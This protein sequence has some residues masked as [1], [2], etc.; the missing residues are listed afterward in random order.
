MTAPRITRDTPPEWIAQQ[1]VAGAMTML[2]VA[3][4][5]GT[6]PWSEKIWRAVRDLRSGSRPMAELIAQ[7][8]AAQ[9]AY[10][11]MLQREHSQAEFE[12][13]FEEFDL[14]REVVLDTAATT[15]PEVL[16]KIAAAA[17]EMRSTNDCEWLHE[18]LVRI[19]PDLAVVPPADAPAV[20]A[21]L[22]HMLPRAGDEPLE[23][24]EEAPLR[25]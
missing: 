24:E 14:C 20:L 6:G 10:E 9:A 18:H 4:E 13:L 16:A 5:I 23:G 8:D 1:V 3:A 2:D 7:Y 17:S 12:T 25:P 19:L 22:A 11:A 21:A 15:V